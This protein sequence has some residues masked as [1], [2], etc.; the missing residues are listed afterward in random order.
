MEKSRETKA[1]LAKL[2]AAEN[3]N[4]EYS[5]KATT[6]AFDTEGRTLVMPVIKDVGE[7]ATDLFLGHEVGHALYTRKGQ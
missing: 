1:L 2:L 7:A 6:A 3:I 5:E 4:V